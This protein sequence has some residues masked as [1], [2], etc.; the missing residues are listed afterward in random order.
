MSPAS[1]GGGYR[2]GF[3]AAS[4]SAI[5]EDR[6]EAV[7]L[8]CTME[9]GFFR[10]LQE[11]FGI[12]I[13]DCSVAALKYAEYLAEVRDVCGW[14]TSKIGGFESPALGELDGWGVG[15]RYGV[16]GLF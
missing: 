11:E 7:I 5:T 13:I 16:E 10:K 6:A 3:Q 2:F 9:F 12:P 14:N 15:E 1:T 4:I 8:G